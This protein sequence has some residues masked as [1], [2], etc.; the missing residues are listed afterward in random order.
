MRECIRLITARSPKTNRCRI[1]VAAAL[2]GVSLD[3]NAQ[4]IN[5]GA[6]EQLFGEPVTTS[7]TGSPLR[8][9]QVPINMV[10]IT[11]ADIRRSGADNIPDVLQ[12]VAGID[13]RRYS[14]SQTDVAIR[15]YDQPYS[16]RL[17][18]LIN[19][20]QVY[21]DYYGYTAWQA[22]PV[23]LDEIR[24][25]EVVKGPSSALFG[26]NAAGGVI[27]IIT[28][29]PLY[30]R[31]DQVTARSGTGGY[32]AISAVGTFQAGK[33]AGLRL[34]AGASQ[35][36]EFPTQ[37]LP[38]IQGPYETSP[39]QL[40]ASADGRLQVSS[41]VELSAEATVSQARSLD[42]LPV[43]N[44]AT[45]DY[46]TNSVKLGMRADTASG[47][48]DVRA[49][50]NGFEY[51]ISAQGQRYLLNDILDVVQASDLFRL[52]TAHTVRIALEY[53]DSSV[54][55][56]GP[57][58]V[59][60]R[61][62]SASTMW[63]WTITSRLAW[64]NSV[65]IDRL[66]LSFNDSVLPAS[67]LILDQNKGLDTALSFNSGLVYSPTVL[68]TVRLTVAR[69][70]QAPSLADVGLQES[71]ALPGGLQLTYS[72][73][74][75]LRPTIVTNYEADYDRAL[76]G[77]DSVLSVAVYYEQTRNLLANALVMPATPNLTGFVAYSQNVGSSAA[78]GGE[79]G[80]KG[81]DAAG[82]RW[83]LSYARLSISQH[84]T[85]GALSSVDAPLD[86][87]HGSPANVVDAGAGYRIHRFEA[88]L[89]GRWQ[90]QFTDYIPNTLDVTVPF[91]VD[92][93]LTLSARFAYRISKHVTA[94]IVGEQLG[95]ARLPEAAG[96]P[97][98]RRVYGTISV[99]Y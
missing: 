93:Y 50:R 99:R 13:V 77:L 88:D 71:Y 36:N 15:G 85:I 10:I 8:A 55:G 63:N 67:P 35:A 70:A 16:P 31:T 58:E 48:I 38:A 75:D 24:Q 94:S 84:L 96:T 98:E 57:H 26:F 64:T 86:Y 33:R 72:G 43:P 68:D 81:K 46:H 76:A 49:Y 3:A 95:H 41:R 79:I 30:D 12:Y 83:N 44:F 97:V 11:Q 91:P 66:E 18:V 74:P 45:A 90:S 28:Y 21:A 37:G 22:L 4:A 29:D 92:N 78:V 51:A 62:F 59:G 80:I 40:S 52:D 17:L 2:L 27:D 54:S 60:D 69:G 1:A 34:S 23:Q 56:L 32:R 65:R 47:L 19:G 53:R 73:N 14:Y 9:S 20:R 5:Y 39:H 7:A 87:A 61:I 89:E 82:L 42:N 6:L 25:I